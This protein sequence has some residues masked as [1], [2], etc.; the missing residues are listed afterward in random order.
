MPIRSL[1]HRDKKNG[2]FV[3]LKAIIETGDLGHVMRDDIHG[4]S[5][6]EGGKKQV[7]TMSGME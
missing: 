7:E 2:V 3:E 1:Y 6:E 4:F 5:T